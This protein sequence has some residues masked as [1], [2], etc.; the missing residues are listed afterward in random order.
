M[1]RLIAESSS[2]VQL[3]KLNLQASEDPLGGHGFKMR[4]AATDK[5]QYTMKTPT[6][7]HSIYAHIYIHSLKV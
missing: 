7:G 6:Y 3:H 2:G 4:Y 1:F 5:P